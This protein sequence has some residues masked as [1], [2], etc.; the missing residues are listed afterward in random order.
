MTLKK[1]SGEAATQAVNYGI[2]IKNNVDFTGIA[3]TIFLAIRF[4][5]SMTKNNLLHRPSQMLKRNYLLK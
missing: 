1:A 5:E 4:I 3:F 2:F